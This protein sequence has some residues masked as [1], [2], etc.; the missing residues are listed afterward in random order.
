MQEGSHY[1]GLHWHANCFRGAHRSMRNR[2]HFCLRISVHRYHGQNSTHGTISLS[3][4]E[5]L[6]KCC[7]CAVSFRNVR[8]FLRPLLPKNRFNARSKDGWLKRHYSLHQGNWMRA[9][10]GGL[11]SRPSLFSKP[12]WRKERIPQTAQRSVVENRK[13]QMKIEYIKNTTIR[14]RLKIRST[15]F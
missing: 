9:C 12:S 4:N 15:K 7:L 10:D 6:T 2:M 1:I 8:F 11:L 14:H 13:E 5:S 3:N